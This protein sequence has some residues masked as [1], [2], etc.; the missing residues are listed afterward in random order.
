MGIHIVTARQTKREYGNH[1]RHTDLKKCLW[2]GPRVILLHNVTCKPYLTI[3]MCKC[4][5]KCIMSTVEHFGFYTV[6]TVASLIHGAMSHSYIP[7]PTKL[8]GGKL[9][10]PCPS[11]RPSVS[12]SVYRIVSAMHLQQHLLN[13]FHICTSYQ[14]TSEGVSRIKFVPKFEI[15]A[16]S[17]N[18]LIWLC[19]PLT[20]DLIWIDS[21]GNHKAAGVSPER[22]NFSCSSSFRSVWLLMDYVLGAS[23]LTGFN[24]R[25]REILQILRTV[26]KTAIEDSELLVAKPYGKMEPR[27]YISKVFVN[28][29]Y[30]PPDK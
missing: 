24:V 13:A 14:T 26:W 27:W 11:V 22:S 1:A 20:S 19:L 8:K 16:K 12:S 17:L 4:P 3:V 21:T 28:V 30:L 10:S 15:L 23:D 29:A 25:R 18:L 2:G 5:I 7:V 6:K 9:V